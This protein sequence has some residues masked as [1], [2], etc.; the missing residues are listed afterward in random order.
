M[1]P[2]RA[3]GSVLRNLRE[4]RKLSQEKLGFACGFHRTYISMLERGQYSPTIDALFRLQRV[5]KISPSA[6]LRQVEPLVTAVR[7]KTAD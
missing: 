3:F 4:R 7:K 6:I 2:E 1:T 5:L